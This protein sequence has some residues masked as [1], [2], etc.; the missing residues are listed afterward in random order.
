MQKQADRIDSYYQA[1]PDPVQPAPKRRRFST[2]SVITGVAI[3][4]SIIGLICALI[5][6]TYARGVTNMA[7][8]VSFIH[9][10]MGLLFMSQIMLFLYF[11]WGKE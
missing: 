10:E 5:I 8:S 3:V 2:T 7:T 9:A 6:F 4:L 11:S 1:T